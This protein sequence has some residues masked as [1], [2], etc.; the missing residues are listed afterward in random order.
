MTD[1]QIVS[2]YQ[3]FSFLSIYSKI[4]ERIIYNAMYKDISD[5]NLL[6]H[7]QSGFYLGPMV[8]SKNEAFLLSANQ[9]KSELKKRA[10]L[11]RKSGLRKRSGLRT[12]AD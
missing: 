3:P 6:S 10:I 1:K 12:G 5:N 8:I 4:F 9:K 2:N 11:R 7:N